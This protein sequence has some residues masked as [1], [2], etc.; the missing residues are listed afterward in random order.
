MMNCIS[1]GFQDSHGIAIKYPGPKALHNENNMQILIVASKGL[2]FSLELDRNP[3]LAK[4]T[5]TLVLN[6]CICP[7]IAL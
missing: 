7:R 4:M 1:S 3:W 6:L 5:N 2:P